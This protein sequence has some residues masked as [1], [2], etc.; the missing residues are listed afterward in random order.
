MET[1][2]LY[3]GRLIDHVHL[4]VPDLAR[5]RP[6]YQSVLGGLGVPVGGEGPGFFW[7]DALFVSDLQSP[8]S[9]GVATGRVHLAFQA[10]DRGMVEAFHRAGLEAGGTD[11]GPPG[12]R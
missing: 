5:T 8:A 4:V 3:R 9:T 12:V 10:Q 7:A 1:G 11:N 6:F 2:E